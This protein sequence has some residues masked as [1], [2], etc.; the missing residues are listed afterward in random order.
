M[1]NYVILGAVGLAA[2]YSFSAKKIECT[3]QTE[4]NDVT[5]AP[6]LEVGQNIPNENAG[7]RNDP[8]KPTGIVP[9]GSIYV[10]KPA[11]EIPNIKLNEH[12]FDTGEQEDRGWFTRKQPNLKSAQMNIID[13]NKSEKLSTMAGKNVK[14][15][16]ALNTKLRRV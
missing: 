3:K 2:Y 13:I 7:V 12:L 11:T 8:T 6:A 14:D 4:N 10:S 15:L 9:I 16:V 5:L 1:N